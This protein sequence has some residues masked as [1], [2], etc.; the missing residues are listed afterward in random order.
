MWK[1]IKQVL[2]KNNNKNNEEERRQ[3]KEL[4]FL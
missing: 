1:V 2:E 3:G 4:D